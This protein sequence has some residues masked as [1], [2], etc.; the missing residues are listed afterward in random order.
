MARMIPHARAWALLLTLAVTPSFAQEP[1]PE[2][3]A[4]VNDFADIID[5][6]AEA[7][8][9]AL[10]RKL[11]AAS[12]DVIVVATVQTFAPAADIRMFANEM[13]ENR[14]RGIGQK[15][16]DNGML[17]VLAVDDREVWVE[18]GYDLEGIVTDGFAG[19]TSR[20]MMA[21]Y[22]RK[23]EYGAGLL[24]GVTVFA[25]RIAEARNVELEG[26]PIRQPVPS[27][28]GGGGFP[29][30]LILFMVMFFINMMRGVMNTLTGGRRGRRRRRWG[31]MV[32]PFGAGYGGWHAGG[33]G[34][35]GGGGF[36]GGFG[37]FGGGR[38][39][40]GGGGASW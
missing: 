8:L 6:G 20:Q 13:F 28:D 4:P 35:G 21:P 22:F 10:I 12:G 37:G 34:W 19:E 11:Q 30:V 38:S 25:Q 29:F 14:G 24:A 40:G 17:V 27:T 7:E 33:R 3:T 16:Q 15:G 31:S 39:G 2:L 9:D 1:P 36:G 23:N 26:V 32:G 5:A 18:V